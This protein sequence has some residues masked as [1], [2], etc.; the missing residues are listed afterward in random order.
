MCARKLLPPQEIR[1]I[2]IAENGDFARGAVRRI[3][4]EGMG[5]P[6]MVLRAAFLRH[7]NHPDPGGDLR[8]VACD[9]E[10]VAGLWVWR[11]TAPEGLP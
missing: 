4:S 11:T 2:E 10:E 8:D 9:H 6:E 3:W 7:H 5:T 1:R